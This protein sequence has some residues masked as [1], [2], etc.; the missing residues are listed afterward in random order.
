[1]S[2]LIVLWGI[3]NISPPSQTSVYFPLMCFAWSL[4][5][6]PR[7]L[8]YIYSEL[9]ITPPYALEW[10][11]YSLFIV[12]YP[13][14]ITGEIGNLLQALPYV[15]EHGAPWDVKQPNTHNFAYSHYYILLFLLSLYV[16][17]SPYMIGHMWDQRKKK[18]G[19]EKAKV[20]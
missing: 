3:T 19:G 4:V 9:G 12:L 14:G 15:K 8:F 16:P 2:R 18:L 7:Y 13:A 20:P 6:V 5:E 10:L 17:G 1:M 11:R